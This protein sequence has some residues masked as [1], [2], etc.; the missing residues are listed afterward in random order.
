MTTII[1]PPCIHCGKTGTVN[2]NPDGITKWRQG[3]LIQHALPE[4]DDDQAEQLINGT[5]PDCW[6][7]LFA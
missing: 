1:T 6:D 5:H 7:E 3:A 2:A 4:L